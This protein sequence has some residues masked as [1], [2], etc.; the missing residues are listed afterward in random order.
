MFL[1]G[2][3]RDQWYEMGLKGEKIFFYLNIKKLFCS[4]IMVRNRK[5]LKSVFPFLV[6]ICA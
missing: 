4:K 6:S 3:E 5:S 2:I 1:G